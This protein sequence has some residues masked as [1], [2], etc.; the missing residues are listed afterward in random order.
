MRPSARTVFLQKLSEV[1]QR[2][3]LCDK[4]YSPTYL[5]QL[6]LGNYHDRDQASHLKYT[7]I[8][9]P[10]KKAI[11]ISQIVKKCKQRS[12]NQFLQ[13]LLDAPNGLND[14]YRICRILFKHQSHLTLVGGAGTSKQELIQLCGLLNDCLVL[15]FDVP[16]F[17]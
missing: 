10:Q 14:L 17:G 8:T 7:N 16:C 3:F 15:E 9:G 2:E 4:T 1:C 6:N 5:E 12:G 13:I 11:A